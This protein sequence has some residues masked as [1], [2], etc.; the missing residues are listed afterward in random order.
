MPNLILVS[1]VE[2]GMGTAT[3]TAHLLKVKYDLVFGPL[4]NDFNSSIKHIT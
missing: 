1:W 2:R 4:S 3:A